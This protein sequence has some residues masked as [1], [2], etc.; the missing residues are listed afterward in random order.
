MLSE[1][2][3]PV[4]VTVLYVLVYYGFQI[5]QA[6]VK[7]RL[8]AEY[9]ARGEKFD[10]YFTQD[11]QML[12][13]DRYQLNMLEHMP[14]F[15]SLLWLHA[16]F[17]SP[18]GSTIGGGIYL[19]ARLVYPLLMGRRLGR[20]IRETILFATVPGYLVILYFAGALAVGAGRAL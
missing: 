13:A 2:A 11:R 10:R 19:A 6:R 9:A 15:L 5:H 1:Y 3:G 12:A 16:V 4:I 8:A 18:L 17:V 7:L 14:P 20:G